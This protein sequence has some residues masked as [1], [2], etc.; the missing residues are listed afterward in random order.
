MP[1]LARRRTRHQSNLCAVLA[2]QVAKAT[3]YKSNIIVIIV[4]MVLMVIMVIMVIIVKYGGTLP[5]APSCAMLCF[6]T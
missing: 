4:I 5:F 2:Q 6:C 1:R 3:L